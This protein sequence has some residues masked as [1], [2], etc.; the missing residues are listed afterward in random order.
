M[1]TIVTASL[2]VGFQL[3]TGAD[4]QPAFKAEVDSRPEGY[5]KG[6]TSFRP[7]EDVYILLYRDPSIVVTHAL[8][9]HG[10]LVK[11]GSETIPAIEE[12]LT[13]AN[14]DN[15]SVNYPIVGTP[16][17]VWHGTNLG[18]LTVGANGS[19]L[20]ISDITGLPDPYVGVAQITYTT[21]ADVYRLTSTLLPGVDEYSILSYFVG[22]QP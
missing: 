12:F 8:T 7:G 3:D 1:A 22:S 4:S 9:T 14:T 13:F 16:V 5:N 6:K 19:N 2:T 18:A 21:Y 11:E 15:A 20:S 10:S 17:T